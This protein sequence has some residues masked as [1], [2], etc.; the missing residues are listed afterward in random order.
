MG[1]LL[2]L[3]L[4]A[5]G[6]PGCLLGRAAQPV[7]AQGQ[8]AASGFDNGWLERAPDPRTEATAEGY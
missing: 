2:P 6:M 4:M 8:V 3:L 7:R 5:A 1:R